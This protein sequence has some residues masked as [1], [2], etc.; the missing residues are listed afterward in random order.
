LSSTPTTTT[1]AVTGS[2]RYNLVQSYTVR[3]TALKSNG[4]VTVVSVANVL[5]AVI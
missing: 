3:V 4:I 2:H 1:F 5:P